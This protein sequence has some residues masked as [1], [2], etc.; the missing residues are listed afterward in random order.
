MYHCLSVYHKVATRTGLETKENNNTDNVKF[1]FLA[2]ITM[3]THIESGNSPA[4]VSI[5]DPR[6]CDVYLALVL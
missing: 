3:Y 5:S 6:I 2:N 1:V 4:L